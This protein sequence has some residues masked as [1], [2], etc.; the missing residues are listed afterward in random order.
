MSGGPYTE[1]PRLSADR[2]QRAI[3]EHYHSAGRRGRGCEYPVDVTSE[4]ER[5]LAQQAYA[6]GA[7]DTEILGPPE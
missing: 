3:A 6:A 1:D 4:R 5:S 7:R 2:R